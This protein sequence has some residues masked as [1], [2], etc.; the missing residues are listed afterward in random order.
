MRRHMRKIIM[1]LSIISTMLSCQS[2]PDYKQIIEDRANESLELS[3]SGI[4]IGDAISKYGNPDD[5]EIS[6]KDEIL[7]LPDFVW[8]GIGAAVGDVPTNISVQQFE[9]SKKVD[10]ICVSIDNYGYVMES[11]VNEYVKR[12][13]IYS[14]CTFTYGWQGSPTY[15]K[16]ER[17]PNDDVLCKPEQILREATKVKQSIEINKAEISF[18]WKWKNG[19]ISIHLSH[20]TPNKLYLTI[21]K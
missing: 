4:K 12:Y 13:G 3:Y 8:D 17:I 5:T 18:L 2:S 9:K 1:L 11:L 19:K 14:S 20:W 6:V 7:S 10:Q 16:E 15:K 21:S